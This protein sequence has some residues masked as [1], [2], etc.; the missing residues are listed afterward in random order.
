M[1]SR[2]KGKDGKRSGFENLVSD[3][4]IAKVKKV[5]YETEKYEYEIPARVAYYLPDFIIRVGKK[6]ILVEAK[7]IFSASD[8]RKLL[9]VRE[10]HPG[11]DLRLLF[12]QDNWLTKKKKSRYSD[13]ARKNGFKYSIWPELPI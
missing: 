9:L 11:L 7:G 10:S 3:A 5:E 1:K 13:W 6:V 2:F 4:L 12:Q 8:R